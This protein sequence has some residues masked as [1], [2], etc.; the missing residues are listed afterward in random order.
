MGDRE[1]EQNRDDDLLLLPEVAQI[2]RLTE[3]TLRWLRHQGQGPAGFRLGRRL[4]FRRG[5]VEAWL[6]HHEHAE[7]K[8]DELERNDHERHRLRPGPADPGDARADPGHRPYAV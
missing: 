5:E 7:P 8:P 2:T 3:S 6:R 1:T 4:L